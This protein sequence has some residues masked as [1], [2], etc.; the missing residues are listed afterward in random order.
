MANQVQCCVCLEQENYLGCVHCHTCVDGVV[1]IECVEGITD[2]SFLLKCPCC[3]SQINHY[4]MNTIMSMFYTELTRKPI[5]NNL[6]ERLY[7]NYRLTEEFELYDC[8]FAG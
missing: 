7:Q 1:C 3:R 8:C 5:T 6:Y 2:T 4:N